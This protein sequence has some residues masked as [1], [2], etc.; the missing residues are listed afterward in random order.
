MTE[1]PLARARR[2]LS[3]TPLVDG[4]NDLAWVIRTSTGDPR[5]V[6]GYDLRSRTSGHTDLPRLKL[7]RVAAQF[8]AAYTPCDLPVH[9]RAAVQHEQI[10]LAREMIRT[11]PDELAAA[12]TAADVRRCFTEGRIAS[13]LTVEGGQAMEGSLDEL[14]SWFS[15][16]V[17]CLTLTHNCTHGWA[18][19]AVDEARHGGLTAFG[20]EVV[21][22]MNRLGM[23]VDLAHAS[24]GVVRDAMATSRAPLVWTHAGARALVDH[25]RNVT[26]ESLAWVREHGGI[27]MATFVPAFVS[28][29]HR[30]WDS[31]DKAVRAQAEALHGKKSPEALEVVRTWRAE[32]PAPRARLSQ[33]AD[34]VEHIRAVAGIDHVG[35]GSDFDGI[36]K[37]VEGLEDVSTFPALFAELARRGWSDED[38][39]KLAGENTLRV[40]EEVEQAAAE[41]A[42]TRP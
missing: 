17:R 36:A 4:H 23:L 7:G 18:D 12:F 10:D 35:I 31:R 41:L 40:M 39:A 37:V 28:P 3:R 42:A 33:V 29:A 20:R 9:E 14:R 13:L 26:D 25:P 15:K 8:W 11:Y 27:V 19:S 32:N 34:H 2:V 30:E 22:E 21:S 16:G 1:A 6:R 38:L 24:D 5:N